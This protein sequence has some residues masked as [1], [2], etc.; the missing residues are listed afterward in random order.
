MAVFLPNVDLDVS[1][2]KRFHDSHLRGP[3]PNISL[4]NLHNVV[5]ESNN[6]GEENVE[7]YDDGLGYYED[8]VKRTLSDEQIKM[9]RHSEIQRLLAARRRDT[10]AK[11]AEPQMEEKN[12]SDKRSDFT[13]E[14]ETGNNSK[15]TNPKV[16]GAG[17]R[18]KRK[19]HF[20]DEPQDEN[21]DVVLD[22]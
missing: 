22:Y 14:R 19:N 21:A 4:A 2:L 9:F 20:N 6:A 16:N 5:S 8:G 18:S 15:R 17:G 7:K 12:N 10:G 13:G 3:V 11:Q 1:K